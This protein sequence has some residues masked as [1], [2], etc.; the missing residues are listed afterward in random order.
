M[1]CLLVLIK[2]M[3]T[4]NGLYGMLKQWVRKWLSKEIM[5][6]T[7]QDATTAGPHKLLRILHLFTFLPSMV[8][9]GHYGLLSSS[10]ME[11]GH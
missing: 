8:I 2:Q 1:K 6:S 9:H 10:Q 4:I 11:H 3:L 7:C 5:E